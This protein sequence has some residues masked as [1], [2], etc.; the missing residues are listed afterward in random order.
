MRASL[1]PWARSVLVRVRRAGRG[2][3]T[4]VGGELSTDRSGR[5]GRGG[6]DRRWGS[7]S[8]R[9]GRGANRSASS[10]S[11]RS[12]EPVGMEEIEVKSARAGGEDSPRRHAGGRRAGGRRTEPGGRSVDGPCV[13][14]VRSSAQPTA[15]PQNLQSRRGFFEPKPK[16]PDCLSPER[17]TGRAC[18]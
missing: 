7:W 16:T 8:E 2:G 17:P 12:S 14:H 3:R 5:A 13:V 11:G 6:R 4:F 15:R 1:P 9:S 10:W 18:F